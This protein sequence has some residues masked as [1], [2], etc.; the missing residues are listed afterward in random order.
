[1]YS[2][3]GGGGY[4]GL[5]VITISGKQDGSSDEIEGPPRPPIIAKNA[6]FNNI[7]RRRQNIWCGG[8]V[9]VI[10]MFSSRFMLFQYFYD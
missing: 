10:F 2:G 9:F 5:V 1:M 3:G 8:G 7:F 6:I 4:Y